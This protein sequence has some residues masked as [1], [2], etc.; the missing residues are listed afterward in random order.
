MQ[1]FLCLKIT[2]LISSADN[3]MNFECLGRVLYLSLGASRPGPIASGQRGSRGHTGRHRRA[4]P[5]PPARHTNRPQFGF[6]HRH[7]TS[8]SSPVCVSATCQRAAM[9]GSI[10]PGAPL[11]H[12]RGN[13]TAGQLRR[14]SQG[15][16][17][18]RNRKQGRE[19]SKARTA[20]R[21]L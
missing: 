9:V 20:G 5:P 17:P 13:T 16:L 11:L 2:S 7:Y 1:E 21:K 10:P 18:F 14:S 6:D 8:S 3:N 19:A 15:L 4:T 12:L